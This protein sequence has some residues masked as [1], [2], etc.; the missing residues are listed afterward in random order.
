MKQTAPSHGE[1]IQRLTALDSTLIELKDEMLELSRTI[2]TV[3]VSKSIRARIQSAAGCLAVRLVW[4]NSAARQL[5]FMAKPNASFDLMSEEGKKYL[6]QFD[7][8]TRKALLEIE[9]QRI[10][11]NHQ[12]RR[13]FNERKSLRIL[14]KAEQALVVYSRQ[15]QAGHES[16]S[17][18]NA[19]S[20]P[21]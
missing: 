13:R 16:P 6:S 9:R 10:N 20:R 8:P 19:S 15:I 3:F 17:R 12:Y 7:K 1:R 5:A 14:H 4:R 2:N 11:L 18:R 21:F